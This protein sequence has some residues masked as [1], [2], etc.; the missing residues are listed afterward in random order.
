[1]ARFFLRLL[2]WEWKDIPLDGYAINTTF[3]RVKKNFL[4][5]IMEICGISGMTFDGVVFV[6]YDK[7][8]S[9]VAEPIQ[10][11]HKSKFIIHEQVH[12]R[13]VVET[14]WFPFHM[15]K[16]LGIYAGIYF[17]KWNQHAY[18]DHPY[19]R[20][21]RQIAGQEDPYDWKSRGLNR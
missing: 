20:E 6:A 11:G 15:M 5:K 2:C 9:R 4:N 3:G 19:E 13:Q 21:A 16:Y 10:E 18:W 8:Q 12:H 1:M 14:G 7:W 17:F